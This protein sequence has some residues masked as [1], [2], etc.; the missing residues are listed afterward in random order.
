M[1]KI[2]DH[3]RVRLLL[4]DSP[5]A[6]TLTFELLEARREAVSRKTSRSAILV[7]SALPKYFRAGFQ[8]R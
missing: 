2:E 5:P 3:G 6:N 1:I 4:L 7:A 8:T